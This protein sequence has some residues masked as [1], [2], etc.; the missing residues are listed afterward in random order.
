MVHYSD[1]L[2][3]FGGVDDSGESTNLFRKYIIATDSYEILT[4]PTV[5]LSYHSAVRHSDRM[6]VFGGINDDGSA[7]NAVHIFSFSSNSWQYDVASGFAL[8]AARYQHAAIA[9]STTMFVHGGHNGTRIFSD[10]WSLDFSS[11]TWSIAT[12]SSSTMTLYGHSMVNLNNVLMIYGGR[13][14]FSSQSNQLY[15]VYMHVDDDVYVPDVV[16]V[17]MDDSALSLAY[18]SAGIV[19]VDSVPSML[20]MGGVELLESSSDVYE[21]DLS[22]FSDCAAIHRQ[23]DGTNDTMPCDECVHGYYGPLE[24]VSACTAWLSCVDKYISVEGTSTSNVVCANCTVLH[25]NDAVHGVCGL[26]HDGYYG[27]SDNVICAAW[28]VC[29]DTSYE[30]YTPSSSNDRECELCSYLHRDVPTSGVCGPCNGDYFG[31]LSGNVACSEWTSD[32]TGAYYETVAPTHTNDR[33]CMPCHAGCMTCSN[34]SNSLVSPDYCQCNYTAGFVVLS[35]A[36]VAQSECLATGKSVVVTGGVPTCT[37]VNNN[38]QD[39]DDDS[40]SGVVV[41]AAVGGVAVVGVLISLLV[42]GNIKKSRS[43]K[44][45][46]D[47]FDV[48]T[49]DLELAS[50]VPTEQPHGLTSAATTTTTTT[51]TTSIDDIPQASDY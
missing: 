36:C 22:S 44:P 32:C 33:G 47:V 11:M 12:G 46:S 15:A 9:T 25:R 34:S 48:T 24:G 2:F 16:V 4:A 17:N 10:I 30:S 41:V 31:S 14:T 35:G 38:V 23:F 28:T 7:S 29:N 37:Y 13:P 21:V 1:C 8:P 27:N 51:A 5:R 19:N 50:A 49:A 6:V 43:V 39:D 3:I 40:I 42:I 26:C 18:H 45:A 20:L